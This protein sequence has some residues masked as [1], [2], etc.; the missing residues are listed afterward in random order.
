MEFFDG[1]T[2]NLRGLKFGLKTP[3]LLFWGLLRLGIVLAI[4]GLFA[5]LIFAYHEEI[6]SLLWSR[7]QSNW[8][9]WVWLLLSWLLVVLLMGLSAAGS[10]LFAQIFFSVLI[11]DL[12]SQITERIVTGNMQV[13]PESSWWARLLFLIKQEVPRAVLPI[14]ISSL[15]MLLG[16]L[17]PLGPVIA[18][19]TTL[20]TAMFL[21]WDNTD[22]IP[23][24]MQAP[25]G[26]RFRFLI[27]HWGFHLGFG[28]WF[29][30]PLVN[31]LFL[32]FAPIGA[33]LY[34]IERKKAEQQG[35]G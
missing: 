22:L 9:Q 1:I 30:I 19:F 24:R 3:K 25:F 21:A 34:H 29:L 8:L 16:W 11:M 23:A 17:T 32:S 27:Q 35:A 4:T 20:V 2:Y 33:T 31:I 5:G 26:Q 15:L 18:I 7:P 6:M 13:L 10:Y 12:M 28:L 14:M